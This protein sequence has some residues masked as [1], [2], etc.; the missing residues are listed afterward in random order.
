VGRGATL[1][2][3]TL[4]ALTDPEPLRAL[5]LALTIPTLCVAVGLLAFLASVHRG[6]RAEVFALVR[7][8]QRAAAVAVAGAAIEAAGI[9]R[10]F[11]TGWTDALTD[12]RAPA[13]LLRLAGAA[14]IVIGLFEPPVTR[15]LTDPDGERWSP[16]GA[17]VFAVVGALIGLVSFAFDGHTVSRGP[18]PVHAA[19]DFVHVTAGSVWAGGVVGLVAVYLRRRASVAGLAHA[20]GRLA[21]GTLV[22]VAAAGVAMSLLIVD[23]PGDFADT[24]WG[25]RLLIK[26]AAVAI[27]ATIGTYHHFRAVPAGTDLHR[28]LAVEAVA[29][30]GVLVI[31]AFLVRASPN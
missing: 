26:L 16:V 5:G 9:A 22:A 31:T 27:A 17:G 11:G 25:R 12:G 23:T 21:T 20:F 28:S 6:P 8:A 29:L 10:L 7:L 3:V 19:L 13:A 14:L 2:T 15:C 24:P 30:L 1:A 4:A 18:R